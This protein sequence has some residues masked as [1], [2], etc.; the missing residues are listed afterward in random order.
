VRGDAS[1]LFELVLEI[2]GNSDCETR[3]L[4]TIVIRPNLSF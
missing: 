2:L 4:T 3:S 1:L